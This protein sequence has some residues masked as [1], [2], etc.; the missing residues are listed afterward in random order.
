[1][2]YMA[3]IPINKEILR[4]AIDDAS[5]TTE[6]FARSIQ[7]ESRT[8]EEWLQGD[9][10]PNKGNMDAAGKVLGRSL[11]FFFLPTPPD[12]QSA[13]RARFRSSLSA[14]NPDA[15][16]QANAIRQAERMQKIVTWSNADEGVRSLVPEA[17]AQ[18]SSK[19]YAEKLKSALGWS[20]GRQK[21]RSKSQ[22]YKELRRQ[23]EALNVLTVARKIGESSCRGFS[24]SS[25]DAPLI[26]INTD[27]KSPALRTFTLLHELAHLGHGSSSVCFNS[28]SDAE[29]WCNKVAADFL[30]PE[31]ELRTYISSRDFT[32]ANA[33]NT[34]PVRFVANY[35]KVSWLAAA[36]R[37]KSIGM[38]D[39]S[40]V[41]FIQDHPLV[42]HDDGFDPNGEARTLPIH[43][44]DE[45]GINFPLAIFKAVGRERL[46]ALEASRMLRADSGQLLQL[47]ALVEQAR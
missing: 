15:T 7:V 13:I 44:F 23:I 22:N 41:E 45:F 31:D 26:F 38:A 18:M 10:K 39:Q 17:S 29:V 9:K 42:D 37:L 34:E 4:W 21:A 36:I 5:L 47:Q 19:T 16:K 25:S 28:D 35:F 1:M 11:Q 46:T 8:V 6:S 40:A 20:L 12:A 3:E 27:Y 24:I 14:E 2:T 43:R 32:Q 30:L 33:H